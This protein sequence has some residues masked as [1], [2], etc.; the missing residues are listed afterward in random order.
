MADRD[1]SERIEFEDELRRYGRADPFMPFD[2]VVSS[3]DRYTIT[4]SDHLAF[5]ANTVV[6]AEPK[7]GIIFFRLGQIVAVE[8]R[9]PQP[10]R[11]G[12]K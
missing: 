12:R 5:T 2:I 8:I 11:A 3:G 6:V 7:T 1:S 10:K 9:E 4:N